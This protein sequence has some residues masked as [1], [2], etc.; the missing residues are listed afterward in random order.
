MKDIGANLYLL[1]L[2]VLAISL[3]VAL[4]PVAVFEQ[5]LYA[6]SITRVFSQ[7]HFDEGPDV[8]ANVWLDVWLS[9]QNFVLHVGPSLQLV[10]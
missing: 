3:E 9:I 6:R 1:P 10:C 2:V 8:I 5:I 4:Y 7:A